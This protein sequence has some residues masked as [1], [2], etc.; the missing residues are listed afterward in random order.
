M[1][2]FLVGLFVAASLAAASETGLI[3]EARR[4]RDAQDRSTL[5]SIAAKAVLAAQQQ[6]QEARLHYEAA[7]IY[8]YLGEIGAEVRDQASAKKAAEA[9]IAEAERAV[10]LDSK[11]A[12]YHRLL[13]TLYGQMAPGA[14][15]SAL[16]FGRKSLDELDRAVALD[17]KNSDAYLSRGVGR[18]YVPPM[19]GGGPDAAL[20]DL[21]KAIELNPKSDQAYLW[22]GIVLRRA[23]RNAEA[24]QSLEQ[25]L[26]LNPQRV[27]ARQ[28]LEKTPAQ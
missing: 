3:E 24:R 5:E 21:R 26:K 18:Y 25:A 11:S 22:Q 6:P 2:Y 12:E 7:L 10:A 27:W 13:G 1:R 23:N 28:Q 14:L 4:A 15:S 17:P 16:K 20:E 19:F 9:G 8:S